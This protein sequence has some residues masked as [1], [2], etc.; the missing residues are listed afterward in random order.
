MT[1]AFNPS[2]SEFEASLVC[3]GSFRLPGRQ[4]WCQAFNPITPETEEIFLCFC[5]FKADYQTVAARA[6]NLNPDVKQLG[7]EGIEGR[8]RKT[9][10]AEEVTRSE[11]EE[12]GRQLGET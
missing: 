4:W 7:E 3:R 5:E 12:A 11:A 9:D 8:R 6:F 1:Y 10:E 2:R